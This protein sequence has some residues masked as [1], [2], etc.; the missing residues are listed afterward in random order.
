MAD[1]HTQRCAIVKS[2]ES[3]SQDCYKKETSSL[4]PCH[5][6]KNKN[7]F[8]DRMCLYCQTF[9]H[10]QNELLGFRKQVSDKLTAH[11]TLI[12]Q[13]GQNPWTFFSH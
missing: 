1:T 11:L 3:P 13:E 6:L 7:G 8:N 10:Y 4:L 9:D 12:N 5:K 2:Y